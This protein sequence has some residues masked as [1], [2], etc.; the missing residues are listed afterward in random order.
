MPPQPSVCNKRYAVKRGSSA[1]NGP[2]LQ[3]ACPAAKGNAW[4]PVSTR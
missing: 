4:Q 2:H 1:A 3:S